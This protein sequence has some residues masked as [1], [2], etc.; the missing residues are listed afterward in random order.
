MSRVGLFALRSALL[1]AFVLILA[2]C[3]STAPATA[4]QSEPETISVSRWSDH[5][6]LF[7]EYQPLVK[8]AKRRFAIHFTDLADF[9]PI[10]AGSVAVLL[11]RDDSVAETFTAEA[12]SRPGIFGVDVEPAREGRYEMSVSLNTP[13]L[14]DTH[15]LGTV[16]V[17]SSEGDV[18]HPRD[19]DSEEQ[20]SFLKEQQWALDFATALVGVET[21]R[22]S[23]TVPGDVRPRTGGEADVIAPFAGRISHFAP[24]AV[25]T[26]VSVGHVLAFLAPHAPDP[27]ER[28]GLEL[29]VA[30]ATSAIRLTEHDRSRAERLVAVGAVPAKRLEEAS[31]AE[32]SARARLDAAEQRLAQFE[33][34]RRSEG[35]HTETSTFAL[36]SPISGVI[37]AASAIPGANVGQGDRLFR[38]MSADRV[39]VAAQVP[40]ADLP[41]LQ[42]LSGAEVV[43]PGRSQVLPVRR[44]VSRAN[45]LDLQSRTLSVVYEV[46]NP[47]HLAV[48][49]AVTVRLFLSGQ[50]KAVALPESAIVD[51]G[52]RPVVFVQTEGE[53][54]AR[55]PVTLGVRHGHLVQV[56]EGLQAGE[57]VVTKGAY[58]IRLAALSNQIPAHGHVH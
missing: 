22:E 52:G 53:A 31:A 4:Q 40:E 27:S 21:L 46:S 28:P 2:G 5:T 9:K 15:A 36:R 43:L 26:H 55:R 25:G 17:H 45:F 39:Y 12:P 11:T 20:I 3:R 35:L 33:V 18:P 54:F 19:E 38:I 37:A 48:G 8:G 58:L 56:V 30:E 44:L 49:Q 1:A 47:G 51:D 13:H 57:R 42:A 32:A 7:M 23:I 34:S 29:A 14:K 41:S 50:V 16:E 24:P 10:S 6:E